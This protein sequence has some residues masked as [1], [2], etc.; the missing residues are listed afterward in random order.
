[1]TEKEWLDSAELS[2]LFKL[3][4]RKASQRKCVLFAVAC[5]HLSPA[6]DPSFHERMKK[7]SEKYEVAV[8]FADGHIDVAEVR[9][10]WLRSGE[11]LSLPER[12]EEWAK[13]GWAYQVV[14]DYEDPLEVDVAALIWEI[15]G[16]P[17]RPV[18][19]APE[20]KTSTVTALAETI[21]ADRT[22]GNLPVLADALEDAGC[23]HAD[24][25]S[26]CR[27]PGSHVRGCWV[28][29]LVLGKE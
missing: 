2:R 17:F 18:T 24:I 1:M 9:R 20:W 27:G 6:Y 15:F 13:Q 16:N 19:F 10:H 28:V 8:Q 25:L 22:F 3:V 14:W 4:E 11:E 12:G 29:D 26:H 5:H 23:D 21:Y 7:D